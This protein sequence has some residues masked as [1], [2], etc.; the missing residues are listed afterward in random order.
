MVRKSGRVRVKYPIGKDMNFLKTKNIFF[1]IIIG[2]I[3]FT[4]FGREIGFGKLLSLIN[5][6]NKFLLLLAI[7]FNL[8]N[9]LSF[10]KT[11]QILIPAKIDLYKLFKFFMVGIFINNITPTFGTGG[12]PIK[13]ILLGD[14]TGIDKAECFA[15]VILQR[16]LNM[17]PFMTIGGTGLGLL[18]FSSDI[19]LQLWQILAL[20][21]SIVIAFCMFGLIIYFY[22][23]KDKLFSFAKSLIKFYIKFFKKGSRKNY[24]DRMQNSID[25][26]YSGLENIQQNKDAIAKAIFF[27]FLGWIFD[28]LAIY[29]VF[30][31]IGDKKI[32]LSIIIITYTVSMMSSWIPFFLPGGLGVVEITMAGLFIFSGIPKDTA[33]LA[34]AIYRLVNYWLNTLIGAVYIPFLDYG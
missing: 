9:I 29:T 18:F 19:K 12:E 7:L 4:I 1:V 13:A 16:M 27:S 22:F 5:N 25:S 10:T 14:E 15:S 26:F 34:T 17:F 20:L 24:L 32:F 2:G 3:I 11:W 28:I 23:R 30:L 33:L 8:M 6:V 31:S 21:F